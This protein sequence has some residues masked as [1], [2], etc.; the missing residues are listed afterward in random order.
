MMFLSTLRGKKRIGS[1]L[2]TAEEETLVTPDFST[3][4]PAR[5]VRRKN[6]MFLARPRLARCLRGCLCL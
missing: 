1:R 6:L 3:P 5:E 2:R 4:F